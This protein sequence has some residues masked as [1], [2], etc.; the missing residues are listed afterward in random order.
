MQDINERQLKCKELVQRSISKFNEA[1]AYLISRDLSERCICARFARY[2]ENELKNFGF[3]DYMV[4]VE[5]NRG[6]EGIESNPKILNYKKIVVDL[7]V[8]KRGYDENYGFSNLICIEMKKDYKR[9][10]LDSDKERLK[11]L[12]DYSYHYCYEAGFM[13]IIH[14]N[15]N[16]QEYA[17][18]IESSYFN[19]WN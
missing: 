4:D 12:V 18:K 15:I 8:H 9:F 14:R 7:I 16:K 5:Y 10:N 6:G 17:L 2:L 3:A 13:I 19:H 11:N 1:E